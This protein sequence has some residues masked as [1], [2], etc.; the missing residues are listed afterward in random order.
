MSERLLEDGF[1]FDVELLAI[2]QQGAWPITELPIMW[3]E[4]PGS[5]LKLWRDLWL[6][7][8]GL[9]RIRRRLNDSNL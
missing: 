3:E 1:V 9:M 7:T 6:M 8:R 5:K 2:L 4:I